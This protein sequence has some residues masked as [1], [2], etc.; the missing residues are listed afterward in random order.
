MR[1]SL[2]VLIFSAS[3]VLFAQGYG[4]RPGPGRGFPGE[5][6]GMG[7]TVTG[8]PYSGVEVRET[9]QTLANGNVINRKT[10]TI[11]YRDSNGR[12]R[13]ENTVTPRTRAGQTSTQA[14][15][16]LVT[17]HDPVAGVTHE[18]NTATK[19][20]R[21]IT[22]H[23]R[24]RGGNT[25]ATTRGGRGA[26][27][28]GATTGAASTDPNVVRENLAMQTINGVQ[29]TGTRTIHTIPAGQRGNAQAMQSVHE[30]W[31]SPDLKIPV[32]VKDSDPRTG[33]RITQLMNVNRSEP[34]PS[35]FQAPSDYKTIEVRYARGGRGGAGR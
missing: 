26:R 35:L 5:G 16:T 8:A 28:A 19:T 14:P 6:P 34:D 11:V 24:G 20:D 31:T 32:M 29:A 23:A 4:R 15:Y 10:E 21:Q 27:T 33:T 18:L 3:S 22:T 1:K 25:A 17:I 13:T 12:T 9:S 7:R 30:V 2:F